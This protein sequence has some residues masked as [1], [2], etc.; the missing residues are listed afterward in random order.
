MDEELKILVAAPI[1]DGMRYC[2]DKFVDRIKSLDYDGYDILL[3]DN[4][5]S[6]LFSEEVRKKHNVNIMYLTL[7]IPNMEKI[8]QSRNRILEYAIEESYDHILMMDCDV[9]PPKDIIEKLLSHKKDIVSGLYYGFFG[10][11]GKEKKESVAW[12]TPTEEELEE[13]R[14]RAPGFLKAHPNLRRHLTDEE[15]ESGSLQEVIIPSA[16]CMLISRNV[17][18]KIRYGLLDVSGHLTSDDIFFCK[19]AREAGFKLYCDPTIKC[20][21]LIHGKFKKEGSDLVHPAFE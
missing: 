16:G 12:K 19:K 3:V 4:S 20:E 14:V 1:F 21:H 7:D 17:F 9:I 6:D 10:P 5:K 15:I 2:M 13:I 18:E 11:K 8:I